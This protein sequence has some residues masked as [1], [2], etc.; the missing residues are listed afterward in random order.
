MGILTF[1]MKK[2]TAASV[3]AF[4]KVSPNVLLFLGDGGLAEIGLKLKTSLFFF[5]FRQ[6]Q[7]VFPLLIFIISSL[8]L[9]ADGTA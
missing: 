7:S 9:T 2:S 3:V 8:S 6:I 5:V 1:I 4:L